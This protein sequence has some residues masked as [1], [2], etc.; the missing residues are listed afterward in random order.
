M[1]YSEIFI[2]GWNLNALM[3]VAN[4]MLAIK[5]M[6][7]VD[8]EKL[9]QESEVLKDLKEQLEKDESSYRKAISTVKAQVL[10]SGSDNSKFIAE[11][12]KVSISYDDV[13]KKV[14]E[15]IS[16]KIHKNDRIGLL[17]DNGT[18]KSTFL[19]A[20]TSYEWQ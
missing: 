10:K 8:K 5:V 13:A 14:L 11:F 15:N 19:K 4:F 2:L 12:H 9:M 1:T 6:S 3:F 17:G 7:N 18:G 20:L 16:I